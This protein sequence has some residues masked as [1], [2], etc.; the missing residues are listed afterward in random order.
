VTSLAVGSPLLELAASP[1]RIVSLAS[2]ATEARLLETARP[3]A[4]ELR[5][6]RGPAGRP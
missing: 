5:S 6:P 3:L 1:A 4:D 2:S